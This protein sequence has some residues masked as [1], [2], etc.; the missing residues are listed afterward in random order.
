MALNVGKHLFHMK[1]II[2]IPL[3]IAVIINCA[4]SQTRYKTD[5][6]TLETIIYDQI[7]EM[8]I[9]L[10]IYKDQFNEEASIDTAIIFSSFL[11]D[12]TQ[13]KKTCRILDGDTINLRYKHKKSDSKGNLIH[14]LDS[15]EDGKILEELHYSYTNNVLIKTERE[16]L[17]QSFGFDSELSSEDRSYS[18]T[19]Y[20]YDLFTDTTLCTK[21]LKIEWGMDILIRN[22]RNISEA[23]TS[24]TI[25]HYDD[26]TRLLLSEMF[27]NNRDTSV[28]HFEY[29]IYNRKVQSTFVTDYYTSTSYYRYLFDTKNIISEVH[30]NPGNTIVI[31]KK[32]NSENKVV[33][34]RVY[35]LY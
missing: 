11:L 20:Y 30:I 10:H 35:N 34:S 12:T 8:E 7:G 21:E 31:S 2:F 24:Q 19:H 22:N 9:Q 28:F 25:Y 32:Y 26:T 17:L 29:D 1:S 5:D 4:I 27:I 14:E 13:L 6:G 18:V 23:D 33:E 3:F 16:L 15:T